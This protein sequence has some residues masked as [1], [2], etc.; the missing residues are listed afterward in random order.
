M[1]SK[2]PSSDSLAGPSAPSIQGGGLESN[3]Q[4]GERV[5]E[6][7]LKSLLSSLRQLEPLDPSYDYLLPPSFRKH[8][9]ASVS[10]NV[11]KNSPKS[12]ATLAQQPFTGKKTNVVA[13]DVKLRRRLNADLRDIVETYASTPAGWKR[14]PNA[15]MVDADFGSGGSSV[16]GASQSSVKG[17]DKLRAAFAL[18]ESKEHE[19]R[20][21]VN[22]TIKAE[23]SR[24]RRGWGLSYAGTTVPQMAMA[25]PPLEGSVVRKRRLEG[26]ARQLRERERGAADREKW[27]KVAREGRDLILNPEKALK[28]IAAESVKFS[29][30]TPLHAPKASASDAAKELMD[31]AV[32][33]Q[34]ETILDPEQ[35]RQR[36]IKEA[37]KRERVLR[38]RLDR[39]EAENKRRIEK[40][41][42]EQDR[43]ASMIETPRD[44]LHRLYKPIF[45]ALWEMEFAALGNTNPF[46]MVIDASTC[47]E[48]GL[49]DYCSIVKRPMNLT[50]VQTKVNNKSYE[51]LQEF[52]EDIDLIAKNAMQYNFQPDNPFY[53]AAKGFRKKFRRLAKPLVESL[54]KGI[55]T[56]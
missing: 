15:R 16:G 44:A 9:K 7:Q 31:Q 38:E 24:L 46:R 53:I 51:T 43:R 4:Q 12:S 37:A 42:E 55:S 30:S 8:I 34:R 39:E 36:Q 23:N 13:S 11:N 47:A 10:T 48:M 28:F 41:R 3:H 49:P 22:A 50:F 18:R 32:K 5:V 21:L 40:E 2:V 25:L 14:R 35:E 33:R 29:P 54:T 19:Q 56:T 6:R 17:D 1:A 27:E 45:T 26:I 52:L 20:D